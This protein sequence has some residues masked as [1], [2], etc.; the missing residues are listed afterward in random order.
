MHCSDE[1][2]INL[3]DSK[4]KEHFKSCE[5][6]Q[7]RYWQLK[8]LQSDAHKMPLYQPAP[9]S[10]QKIREKVQFEPVKPKTVSNNWRIAAGFVVGSFLSVFAYHGWQVSMLN[11]EIAAS[12]ELEQKLQLTQFNSVNIDDK[13]WQL[14]E[15]DEQL[16][17]TKNKAMQ[18][19]LWRKRNELLN[20]LI[21]QSSQSLE[22]I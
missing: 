15:I 11:Q 9:E 19:E 1:Q 13:L 20:Q 16:N 3:I 18:R 8:Q 14:T 10:W 6:C 17:N 21:Q 12:T 4:A 2:L 7:Q 22:S 5:E